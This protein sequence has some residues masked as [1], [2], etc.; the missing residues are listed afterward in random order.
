MHKCSLQWSL[1]GYFPGT[2]RAYSY[3]ACGE[4]NSYPHH[5]LGE[6]GVNGLRGKT[7]RVSYRRSSGGWRGATT[8]TGR[9][10]STRCRP[11]GG[12]AR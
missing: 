1:S 10:A 11:T 2:M 7:L 3:A 4:I 5:G 12:T 6:Y 8:T 9:G